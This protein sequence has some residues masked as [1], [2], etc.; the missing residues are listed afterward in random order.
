MKLGAHGGAPLRD[1]VV[2]FFAGELTGVGNGFEEFLR[3]GEVNVG[4]VFL[5]E[6][7]QQCRAVAIGEMIGLT[8]SP[9]IPASGVG[10]YGVKFEA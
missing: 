2:E 3:A 1:F 9:A 7:T 5:Y 6:L 10:W 4:E 8:P